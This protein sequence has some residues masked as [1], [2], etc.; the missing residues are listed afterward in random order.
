MGWCDAMIQRNDAPAVQAFAHEFRYIG[1]PDWL[2]DDSWKWWTAI[3]TFR[4][5]MGENN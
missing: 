3:D 5:A 4:D 2:P 1:A